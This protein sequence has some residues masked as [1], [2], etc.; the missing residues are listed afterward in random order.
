MSL[1]FI[2]EGHRYSLDGKRPISV[3]TV[4]SG[5]V[6]KQLHYW[7]A[8]KAAEFAVAN[9]GATY[10][11]IRKAPWDERDAAGVRGTA[12]HNLA[13]DLV[14]GRVVEVPE[15]LAPYI[16][17]YLRF[18]DAFGIRPLLTECNIAIRS[19]RVAGRFDL[20]ATSPALNGGE[21]VMIDLKT[22]NGIYPETK[23]QTAA[24]SKG[25]F[26]TTDKD[27]EAELK[28]PRIAATYVAH[29]TPDGTR[30]HPLAHDRDELETH[31]EMF[32]AA[33]RIYELG[34]AKNKIAAEIPYPAT[35]A[36]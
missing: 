29:V 26:Y 10:D 15:E 11:Q 8:N 16:D 34:L 23:L 2:Q 9:P 33:Y 13:E 36:A 21:P 14:H 6:P 5:G 32:Q 18:L 24:Y 20:I 31:F 27:G 17:G 19:L 12:V 1:T 7:A 35:I 25:D 3:T 30:L 22:S 28:L 4:L